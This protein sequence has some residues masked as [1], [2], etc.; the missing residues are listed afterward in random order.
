M[1]ALHAHYD[2]LLK[3]KHVV[4][5]FSFD[6]YEAKT[7]QSVLKWKCL[8]CGM[9][10][11][12]KIDWNFGSLDGERVLARCEKCHPLGNNGTSREEQEFIKKIQSMHSGEVVSRARVLEDGTDKRFWKEIDCYLPSLKIGFEYDGL[13]FHQV[14]S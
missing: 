7:A 4:P 14:E 9:E 5:L 2:E 11:S 6:E 8:E 1:R 3:N 10:F 13:Y 12:T